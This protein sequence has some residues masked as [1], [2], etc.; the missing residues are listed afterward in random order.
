MN[1][2]WLSKL[3]PRAENFS[4]GL[5]VTFR[6]SSLSFFGEFFATIE[7]HAGHIEYHPRRVDMES[8]NSNCVVAENPGPWNLI[9]KESKCKQI[10]RSR[11]QCFLSTSS[12][13]SHFLVRK[14]CFWLMI[15]PSK[16]VVSVGYSFV[17]PLIF[18]YP[19]RKEFSRSTCWKK[20][21]SLELFR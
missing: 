3:Q 6:F 12:S 5:S 17:K 11:T 18:K 4:L 20:D 15:S 19:H 21:Q 1:C 16:Y 14:G 2:I 8:A 9:W 13:A 10:F 7:S